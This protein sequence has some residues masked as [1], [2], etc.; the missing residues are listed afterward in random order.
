MIIQGLGTSFHAA[1]Y[2]AFIFKQLKIFNTV[3][4]VSPR[5]VT[6]LLFKNVKNGGFLT[7]SRNGSDSGLVK[8]IKLAY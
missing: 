8:A 4:V 2:G 3:R 1:Q 7:V 5:D 6:P